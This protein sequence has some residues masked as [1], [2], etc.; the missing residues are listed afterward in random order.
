ML[1]L[2][3]MLFAAIGF[4]LTAQEEAVRSRLDL[5]LNGV[6]WAGGMVLGAL[7]ELVSRG[8]LR[9]SQ[10]RRACCRVHDAD[11]TVP[12]SRCL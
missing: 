4:A 8:L 6:V 10:S 5:T 9:K 12:L 3:L 7:L 11:D 1:A 2:A